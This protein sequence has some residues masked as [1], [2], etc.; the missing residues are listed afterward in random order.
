MLWV[1]PGYA[2]DGTLYYFSNKP[3]NS[4]TNPDN[5]FTDANL[6]IPCNCVPDF[7]IESNKLYVT[8][9]ATYDNSVGDPAIFNS[10]QGEGGVNGGTVTGDAIFKGDSSENT[11]TISGIKTRYYT[12]ADIETSRDFIS[13]G[14]W[15]IIADAVVVDL[16]TATI[17]NTTTLI[18]TNGGSFIGT[19]ALYSYRSNTKVII[20]YNTSLD[21]L[22]IP[23]VTDFSVLKNNQ[24]VTPFSV[25]IDGDRVLLDVGPLSFSDSISLSYTSGVHPIRRVLNANALSFSNMH[26]YVGIPISSPQS[27]TSFLVGEKIYVNTSPAGTTVPVIDTATNTLITEISAVGQGPYNSVLRGHDLYIGLGNDSAVPI[28]DT[29]SNTKTE[30]IATPAVT[31]Y[32]ISYGNKLYTINQANGTVSVINMDTNTFLTDIAVGTTPF[33]PVSTNGKIYITNVASQTVSVIDPT[34]D[35]V[36]STIPVGS[37]PRYMYVVGNKLYVANSAS[38][39]ISVINTNTDSVISTISVGASPT[40]PF[41]RGKYIYVLNNSTNG[42]VSVI[43]TD[44]DIVENTISVGDFPTHGLV[45]NSYAYIANQG[46]QD[47]SIIDLH[48]QSVVSTIPLEGISP[49]FLLPVNNA[50]YMNASGSSIIIGFDLTTTPSQL[51]NLQSFSTSASSGSYTPGQSI[52]VTAHFGRTLQAG[53][54]MTVLMNTGRSVVLNNVSGSTLS[55]TYTIQS[56]DYTPDLAIRS[57]TSANVSDGTHTRTS[58]DLPSSVG[59]F[60]AENSFITRNLGDTKNINIGSYQTFDTGSNPYQIAST[61]GFLYTANQGAGTVSVINQATGAL[62]Q[63]ITVG[64]EPYGVVLLGSEL[65]VVNTGSDTVSVIDTNTNTVTHTISVGVKPYYAAAVGSYVYVTN[66]LSNTVSVINTATHSVAAT[67]PVGSYPRGIKAHGTD[68]YVANYGD[69]N[70]SGGNYISV[71]NSLTNQVTDTI[72][73]PAGSDGPRGVN[74]LG[75][76]V[77]VTNFRSNNVS[78]IDTNTNTITDTIDVGT[79]PRG[80]AGTGTTLYVE[81]FDDGTISV[82]DTNTNTVTKTIDVGSSPSGIAI[83]GTIAY[84]TSFQDNRIYALNTATNELVAGTAQEEEEEIPTASPGPSGGYARPTTI[85]P[86]LPATSPQPTDCLPSYRFSP[87]TGKACIPSS[88]PTIPS[89]SH[90]ARDLKLGMTGHDVK[91]LQQFLNTHNFP[92]AVTGLGS[93]GKETEKFGTLTQKALI[94]FQ[95]AN[96]IV[97]S[98]GYFGKVTRGM[99]AKSI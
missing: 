82:I 55:G 14:P 38:N 45:H 27:Y 88:I 61:N 69:P 6:E 47:I 67:I 50:L 98:V 33:F 44:T 4:P 86:T 65:Y 76:K 60:T 63:T 18:P 39:T 99:I 32:V 87:T 19:K 64:S 2:A 46:S 78:V 30:T 28:I 75:S 51:P 92:V 53:S 54:T 84:V 80:I 43:N 12:G 93:L 17:N 13:D 74:V 23:E 56:G 29:E 90:F 25:E 83:S 31:Y 57:I 15:E 7:S 73:L 49:I 11:G 72:I 58:Y 26:S 24:S 42:S 59:S 95:I 10:F 89:T 68:L 8:E 36:I 97:P 66:S 77:Y 21:A 91:A 81:N 3:D 5:Y 40:F 79:G 20:K 35:T 16:A 48:S 70:Y 34:T 71:I 52:P 37:N 1:I 22:S 41:G 94:K 96:K 9:G 85:Q 62:T